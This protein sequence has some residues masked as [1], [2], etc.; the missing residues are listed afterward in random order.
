M[1]IRAVKYCCYTSIVYMGGRVVR[2]FWYSRLTMQMDMIIRTEG[3]YL[4]SLKTDVYL[5]YV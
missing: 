2:N 1:F 3:I 4:N 5:L